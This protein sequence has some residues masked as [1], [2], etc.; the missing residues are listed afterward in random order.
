MKKYLFILSVLVM[1][2]ASCSKNDSTPQPPFDPV[3][4][5]K[6]DDDAIKAYLVAHPTITAVKDLN[7][8]EL[9]YQVIQAGSGAV[10]TENS[11]IVVSYSGTNLKDVVFDQS[12][13]FS[14]KLSQNLIAGFK[15]AV[16]QLKNGGK[17]LVIIPSALGYGPYANGPLPANSVLVFTITIKSVDGVA[18]SI[19]PV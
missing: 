19:D 18:P 14:F 10:L 13:S 11:Q 4:Q 7:H 3:A 12:D 6:I 1:G 15:L 2:L 9:Y 16:S 5:A 17:I 8:P